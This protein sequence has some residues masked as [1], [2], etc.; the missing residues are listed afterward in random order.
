M[1]ATAARGLQ[2]EAVK[3]IAD[4]FVADGKPVA[5]IT[6]R[7]ILAETGTGSLETIGIHLR[8]YR[9]EFVE[10]VAEDNVDLAELDDMVEPIRAIVARKVQKVIERRDI[11][12]AGEREKAVVQAD[13]LDFALA[14]NTELE[15]ENAGLIS[16]IRDLEERIAGSVTRTAGLEGKLDEARARY[17]DLVAR[18]LHPAAENVMDANDRATGSTPRAEKAASDLAASLRQDG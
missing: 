17:D 15:A 18:L 9:R 10:T 13:N 5:R 7:D 1:A 14:K 11:E 6:Y 2:Y 4:K 12:Q 16:R 3:T 8:R